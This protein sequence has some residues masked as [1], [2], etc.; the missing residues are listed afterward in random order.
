ME[1]PGIHAGGV[2]GGGER[3][4]HDV[5]RGRRRAVN[6]VPQINFA[7]NALFCLSFSLSFFSPLYNHRAH[8]APPSPARARPLV[9]SLTISSLPLP[10]NRQIYLGK[11]SLDRNAEVTAW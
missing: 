1:K 11:Y 2:R 8:G 10:H 4:K 5:P 3:K 9:F 6:A 7:L